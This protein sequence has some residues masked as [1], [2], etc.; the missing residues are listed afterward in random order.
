MGLPRVVT[1][2]DAWLAAVHAEIA[3]LRADIQALAPPEVV[4]E[5][6]IAPVKPARR[7]RAKKTTTV[8]EE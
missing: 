8:V 4:E 3:G 2:T 6:A 5:P 7:A 1:T